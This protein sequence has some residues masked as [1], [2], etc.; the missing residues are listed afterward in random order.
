M[1]T[2]E[3]DGVPRILKQ[4]ASRLH[5][6]FDGLIDLSD[7]KD[8]PPASV[9][10]Y[11]LTRAYCALF[12]LSEL[13]LSPQEAANCVIDGGLDDGV[14]AAYV[15][16]NKNVIFFGQSKF[17]WNMNKGV[18]LGEFTRFRDGVKAAL[19]CNWNEHN[20]N[21][22]RFASAIEQ[23][24]N[25]IDTTVVVFFAHTSENE[26]ADNI[27]GKINE[28][29]TASNKY[30][31]NFLEFREFRVADA[32]KIARSYTRPESI[33]V[34]LM[35]TNWGLL[36][37]P[38]KAVYGSVAAADLVGWF[39]TNGNKL[40]AEN[41]RYG[42]EKSYVNDGIIATASSEPEKFWYFNNGVTAICDSFSKKPIGGNDTDQGV[43]DI[44]KVSVING[45]QTITSLHKAK[46]AGADLKGVRVHIRAISLE[47]TPEDFAS[48]VTSANNTQNDLNP[49]DFVAGDPNQ[50]RI[51][52]EAAALGLT[53]AF[54]RGDK[55]PPTDAG[56]TIRAA[57][58]AAACAS[59]DLRLAVSAKRYISG[60]WENPKKE[61]Y[62]K[63]FNEKTTAEQLWNNVRV[64]NAVDSELQSRAKNL[65]GRE[66]LT[67]V[68]G[69]RFILFHVF[70]TLRSTNPEHPEAEARVIA[71][72]TLD[73]LLGL[74]PERFP[75]AYPGN[76]F[77]NQDRQ[78][79]LLKEL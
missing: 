7:V 42:I 19:D 67:A 46:L 73:T 71:D 25:N 23:Q 5:E 16:T 66:R 64:M 57:T 58:V 12:F 39:D 75:E 29:T 50:E 77:K 65:V 13:S 22:H 3:T 59:G 49:V 10:Q 15:D 41:L 18:E 32:A 68:H 2:E 78:A 74:I 11:F 1:T 31:E 14:D 30:I 61:P 4:I 21:I 44:L 35:L 33:D 76:V 72:K 6:I 38:Y 8:K 47:K 51:R 56:F 28:Y 54:R 48:R 34:S 37:T 53:Y 69:N 36:P 27:Y 45:A 43:F 40:F 17:K 63:L 52:K 70:E 55:D 60:L 24:L 9:E 79:E 62:T 26:I 20:K